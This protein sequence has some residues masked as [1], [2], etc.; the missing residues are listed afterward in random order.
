MTLSRRFSGRS[1]APALFAV[2]VG[3]TGAGTAF[4]AGQAE[5]PAAAGADAVAGAAVPGQGQDQGQERGRG[6]RGDRGG[7]ENGA[8]QGFGGARPGAPGLDGP[9]PP[10]PLPCE[11]LPHDMPRPG[12]GGFGLFGQL[13]R[14]H[15]SE[16]QEDKLFALTHA[17][18]PQQRN[19][20]KAERKAHEALRDLGA[21][22][23]FDE[24]RAGA[25]ARALG[26]AIANRVLLQARLQAQ[27]L[28]VLTPEQRARL[29]QDR[30][31]GP[32]QRP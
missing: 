27:V 8:Q 10:A 4:A 3:A 30:P 17:A 6:P 9:I 19:Q 22:P 18:A 25:A 5:A 2:C 24:A 11:P 31:P 21:A 16:A 15:L 7:P 14:L 23:Q 12:P 20:E 32:P 26:Q 29:R 13:H 1:V 28:A